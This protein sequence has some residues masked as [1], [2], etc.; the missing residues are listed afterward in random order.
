MTPSSF[1]ARGA[2]RRHVGILVLAGAACGGASAQSSPEAS[3]SAEGLA[4]HPAHWRAGIERIRLPGSESVGLAG[5]SYLVDIAHGFSVGP[6]VYG[7]VS[8][9]RGGMSAIGVEAAWRQ[10]LVGPL[11]LELGVFAGG[12]GGAGAPVGGGLMLRPHADLL[13][14]F[15]GARAGVSLSQVRFPDGHFHSTQ[16]GLVVAADTDFRFVDRTQFNRPM[17]NA[18]SGRTGVG[19]DRIQGVFSVL[20]PRPG[21]RRTDGRPMPSNIGM[22][23]VRMEQAL[24]D[25]LYW[26]I[27]AGGAVH[28]GLGGYTEYLLGGG[29]ET[30][31]SGDWLTL[32]ARVAA[33]KAGGAGVD[34]GGGL[35]TKGGLYATVRLSRDLGLSI[36]GGATR[37]PQGNFS[38]LHAAASLNWIIDDPTDVTAPSRTA[39]TEW[40]AGIERYP[41]TLRDGRR[42]QLQAVALKVN[43]FVTPSIYLSGQA[44]S[45]FAGDAGGYTAGLFGAG[46]QWP[47]ASRFHVG[48]EVVAGGA[49]GG[50][51]DRA[52]GAIVQPSVYVG[53]DLTR[54][55]S[56]RVGVGK[57]KSVRESMNSTVVDAG[58]VFTFGVPSHGY[59]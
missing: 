2:L 30:T 45:A 20:H 52:G 56:L 46:V 27:E 49:G 44:H 38:A 28:G 32:G 5:V 25:H 15:H 13:W 37:A 18:P 57:V 39:R 41:V 9:K 47:F 31:L 59:R 8:G 55:L 54:S 16:L 29:Y 33:G 43:R 35:M 1:I 17:L 58:L 42:E 36:E 12:G 14:D 6:G 22:A 11:G 26:G 23:G 7:A 51:V 4:R 50:G 3:P 24:G 34:V 19:F 53:A 10:S 21:A 40:V 48:A